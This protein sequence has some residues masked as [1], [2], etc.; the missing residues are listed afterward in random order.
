MVDEQTYG[1]MA[2]ARLR[3]AAVAIVDGET[4][5]TY[6]E[7]DDRCRRMARLLQDHGVTA[8][9]RVAVMAH[10]SAGWFV[11]AH[12]AGRLGAVVV[13]VNTHSKRR[14]AQHVITDSGAR[15]V[16]VDPELAPVLDGLVDV[17]MLVVG[18]GLDRQLDAVDDAD[19]VV[20]DDGWPT[21]M[22]YTSG[23]TGLPK[24]V[25]PGADDFRRRAAGV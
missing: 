15:A 9:D 2:Q 19:V 18:S 7:L 12:G 13:P 25:A 10:N 6:A 22:L 11:A 3:P 4:S 24:G 23:T 20:A 1:V 17:A 21:T 16:V 14:E 8:G 5:T